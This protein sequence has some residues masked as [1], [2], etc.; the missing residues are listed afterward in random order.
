MTV[1]N[2]A[3]SSEQLV[4]GDSVTPI[5]IRGVVPGFQV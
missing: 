4:V 5:V 3:G 1:A 2:F